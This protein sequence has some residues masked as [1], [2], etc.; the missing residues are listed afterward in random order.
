MNPRDIVTQRISAQARR[1]PDL[2]LTP[3]D[4]SSLS[5]RDASLVRAIDHIVI[6]RWLTI[7][8]V[9]G[10]K[11]TQPWQNLQ[12]EVQAPLLVGAAQM[13]FLSRVPDHAIVSSAVNW[14][15]QHARSKAG[16]LVNAVL[17]KV[18]Q[19]R[20]NVQDQTLSFPF[21]RDV[22]LLEDGRWLTL[23]EDVFDDEP[24]VRL[25][26]QTSH[27]AYLLRR[28]KSLL[29]E[30]RMVRAALHN[31]VHPPI[32]L[33]GTTEASLAEPNLVPHT[34]QG[35]AVF[36][37]ERHELD[38]LLARHP[39]LRVQD[40][41]TASAIDTMT[42]A[43]G[44]PRTIL[45][46][47]AGKGTKT[48]QLA[49]AFPDARILATDI[50]PARFE[51][52]RNAPLLSQSRNI[53]IVEF[54]NI[55]R[56]D[57]QV[58]VL[59]VDAPCS[60]SGVLARRMEARYRLTPETLEEVAALQR[61]ILADA[62]PLLAPEGKILY[63]TCSIEPLENEQQSAWLTR[64]HDFA[65]IREHRRLPHGL[66]GEDAAQYTDGGYAALLGR[67]RSRS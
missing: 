51:V 6:R 67:A 7:A 15:K 22:V 20:S 25:A 1:F 21:P 19:L 27:P 11:T 24:I 9:V 53:D 29:G 55:R 41:G 12:P 14:T 62:I 4:V 57:E 8:A 56:F 18:A 44:K 23:T 48:R 3:L 39:L 2:D 30:R 28:W 38:D 58:D 60:N 50:D 33:S 32:V 45:D 36:T 43:I 49:H 59:V 26:Q 10:A 52:L 40:A 13:L 31:L 17:R 64:W 46:L 63:I 16:G 61:Q 34:E 54:A 37:G 65:V 35:C 66:P 42:D 47:C 5:S